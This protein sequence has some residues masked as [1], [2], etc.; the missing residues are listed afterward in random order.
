MFPIMNVT[1]YLPDDRLEYK[2]GECRSGTYMDSPDRGAVKSIYRWSSD[3]IVVLQVT[4]EG[5]EGPD[6]KLTFHNVPYSCEE[7]T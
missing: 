3:G 6:R 4:C 2:V 1:I 5:V 7:P